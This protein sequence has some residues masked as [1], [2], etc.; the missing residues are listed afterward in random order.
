M[1]K[2]MFDKWFK[3][4]EASGSVAKN[5]LKVVIMQDRT[6]FPPVML[7]QLK[8]DLISVFGKYFE[9]EEDELQ[10]FKI[11]NESNNLGLSISIPIK[12]V[13]TF[14]SESDEK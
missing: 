2:D 9:M 4:D 11:E 10:S 7:Q 8:E 1:F 5:R 14:Q 13:R 12:K 3:K 6:S